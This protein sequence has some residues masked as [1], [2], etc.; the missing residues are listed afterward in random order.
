M[1]ER[2][3]VLSLAAH[4]DDAEFFCAGTLTLLAERGWSVHIATMTAGDCGTVQYSREEIARIRR[5][6]AAAAAALIGATYHCLECDDAFVM[7]D[8]PT[9]L[10]V[11]ALIRRVQP[12]IVLAPCREDYM[13]DHVHTSR[14]AMTGCFCAGVVNID[15]GDARPFE[16]TPHLYYTDPLEGKDI[17][18]RD[19]PPSLVVDV[20]D[21]F[22]T[23]RRMLACH[24][25]QRDWLLTH[26]GVDEYIQMMERLS[27]ACGQR[28]GVAYGEGFRQH[29][30]SAFPQDDRLSAALGPAAYR[31]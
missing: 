6:E 21:V 14:L 20:A 19:V 2:H 17:Y 22:E 16:P 31:L 27:Q 8:R 3:V 12:A 13:T 24:A 28:A 26:H 4:P 5:N 7:Y 15:T 29:L 23:K 18:G 11:I 1:S 30:G 10:K 9:L 25:S